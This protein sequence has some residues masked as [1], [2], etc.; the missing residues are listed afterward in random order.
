MS[1]ELNTIQEL[2]ELLKNPTTALRPFKREGLDK[3]VFFAA[4]ILAVAFVVWGFVSPDSLGNVAGTLLTGVMDN[5]GWLF[6]IAATI[7]TIFVIVVAVSRFGRIPLGR[8]DEK[9]EFKTSSWIAMMFA[10][11]MGIGL[12]FSAVGEPLF[13]YMSPPPNTVDGSTAEAMGT[14]MGTTLFHWTLYPWAMYAIVGLGVA[15]GSFRLGRS[16]LFSSMFTPLF[17]ERAVNGFGGKVINI[18]AI[19][20]TLFGS[21]CSLGLGAIQIGGGIESAGIMSEVTSPVLVIIIAILTAAFVVSAVSGVEKGI[22]WLS[23]I[24]MVL[25]VIVA[26]IVFIGGPTLFILNVVPSSVGAFIQDLPQLASRTA[27]DGQGVNEWLSSW[28]VFY[29]AWWVSWSPFVGLFIARISRGRTVRQ[30]VTGVLIVPSVVSTIWFAVFGGGAIGIQERAERGEGTVTALAKVVDGEPDINMDTILFDLL[31]ALP[32][33]NL[34]A[35]ILM[36]VTVILIAIFFVTGADS[37]SIVMGTLSANGM[38]EPG[39][40]L[41]IFWGT[42]TGAVAAVMLLAGGSDPAEALDGLKNITIVSALPFVIV[43]LLLCVAVWK[44][45]SKDPLIIQEQLAAH[46]LETSVATAVNEYDGEI[47][48]LKTSELQIE[49]DPADDTGTSTKD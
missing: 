47:F 46:V 29:W 1:S 30:F 16:Q 44:D 4:G 24:N 42:A 17:G 34:I 26:L 20:A 45:L 11:G 22:Q 18:L 19:L 3:V 14:S 12:V 7:F 49:E 9:P 15:Y 8:D 2:I 38:Q 37:A 27:A 33:P 13:F 35:I 39:K 10:T 25:A 40:G 23:N 6:V 43:M 31:G 48:G 21:A 32:L 5:F 28:T 41:V 36:I